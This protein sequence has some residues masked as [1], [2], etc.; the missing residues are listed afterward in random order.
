MRIPIYCERCG[1]LIAIFD[2]NEDVSCEWAEAP[3]GEKV[4]EKC[5]KDCAS[6]F[7]PYHACSHRTEASL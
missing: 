3:C 2:T 4:C 5:C 7:D 1:D 6:T